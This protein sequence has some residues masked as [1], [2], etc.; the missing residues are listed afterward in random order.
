MSMVLSYGCGS[1]SRRNG[2]VWPSVTLARNSVGSAFHRVRGHS[3]RPMPVASPALVVHPQSC[4]ADGDIDIQVSGLH[5]GQEVT[6]RAT[7][8]TD[9][10]R[11]SF[12]SH[13]TYRA[14]HSG[15]IS[16]KE[17]VSLGGSYEGL[18]PAG[19]LW[20][21]RP[22][23]EAADCHP[24]FAKVDTTKPFVYHLDLLDGRGGDGFDH[25]LPTLASTSFE[26]WYLADYVERTPAKMGRAE[27]ETQKPLPVVL[28]IRGLVYPLPD[29]RAA[30]LASHGFAVFA[31]DYL[32]AYKSV[33]SDG[34]F[35]IELAA[36]E[37]IWEYIESHHALDSKRVGISCSC[38]GAAM[39]LQAATRL[40]L[41]INCIEIAGFV[42]Y[43][44]INVGMVLSDGTRIPP[45]RCAQGTTVDGQGRLWLA[46]K[47]EHIE[48]LK[49]P[50][51]MFALGAEDALGF[52][53]R[54]DAIKARLDKV[55]KQHLVSYEYLPATTH[56][57][58]AP[59]LPNCD[60]VR[61]VTYGLRADGQR[62]DYLMSLGDVA[63]NSQFARDQEY[64]WRR[65]LGFLHDHLGADLYRRDWLS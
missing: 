2:V 5:S 36:F 61:L 11:Y 45:Y 3:T 30:L 14:N 25:T 60:T 9:C 59:Y 37:D 23:P 39:V 21:L 13:A 53:W 6:L 43:F 51:L 22:S 41:P 55:G 1:D 18:E 58:D 42:D 63:G 15:N 19:L 31:F 49:C 20:S 26:R 28:D 10:G 27:R 17:D 52:K 7:A 64:A 62:E 44:P 47:S 35:Y 40:D 56:F 16:L 46:M 38:V 65:K 50:M 24:R 54:A 29:Y 48:N 57:L 12:H 33:A 34:P 32:K 4:L 8:W